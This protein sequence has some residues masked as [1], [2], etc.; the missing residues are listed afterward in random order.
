MGAQFVN[1]SVNPIFAI[2]KEIGVLD[3][4]ISDTEHIDA[5]QFIY[6]NQ[7]IDE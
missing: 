6:G 5:A 7:P 2:A 4:P 1:G 3:K